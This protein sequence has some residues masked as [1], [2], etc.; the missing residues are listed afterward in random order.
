[1]PWLAAYGNHDGLLQGPIALS[2]LLDTLAVGSRK[3]LGLAPNFTVLQLFAALGGDRTLFHQLI[4]GPSRPVTP[5][6]NRRLLSRSETVGEYFKTT[7]K[8]VGHGFTHANRAH[9]TAYYTFLSGGVRCIVLDSVNPNG[10]PNGS[11][12]QPQLNWLT[13]L[14]DANSKTRLRSDGVRE[15]AGGKDHLIVMFS[16]HTLETMDNMTPGANAPGAR[17]LGP[18]LQQLLLQHPNVVAWVNGHTHVNN[19]IAHRRPSGWQAAEVSGRSTQPRT[20]TSPSSPGSW[21]WST[22]ATGRCQS[23]ARS[24]TRSRL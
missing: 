12:D 24:S 10:G 14:L 1:M 9:G 16:H 17:I 4:N 6:K 21:N 8:P 2:P 13:S 15:P 11:L 18:Q 19:I 22:I 3:I 20:S 7:G 23:S 5:D